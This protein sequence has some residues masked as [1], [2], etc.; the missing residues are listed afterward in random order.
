V[1]GHVVGN[2]SYLKSMPIEQMV[3]IQYYDAIHA[4]SEFGPS[5]GMGAIA[6]ITH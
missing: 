6:V 5:A 4:T 3:T 1:E 2:A